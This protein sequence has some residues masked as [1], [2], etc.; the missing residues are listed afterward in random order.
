MS[1]TGRIYILGAGAIGSPLAAYLASAGRSVVAVRTSRNDVARDTFSIS[2]HNDVD[3]LKVSVETVSLSKLA[4]LE[5]IIVITAKSYA[6]KSI[7]LE[8][9]RKTVRGSL[10]IMQNGVGVERPFLDAQ[11]PEVHRCVLYV[12]SQE[13]STNDFAFRSITSSPM[14]VVKGSETDLEKVVGKLSTRGLP[15]HIDANI[16][17]EIWKKAIVNSV[18]NSICP[19]LDTDNGIFVRDTEAAKLANEVVMECIPLANRLNLALT[20][21]ELMDQI[22]LISKRSDGQLISTLQDI[23]SGRETEI[24]FLNLEMA[25]VA[26]SQQPRID[27]PRTELLGKMVLLKAMQR[28][29]HG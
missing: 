25:R 5:G 6:N 16:Q 18:F 22:M 21:S 4:S 23:K 13:T 11:F 20:A 26:A 15:I 9:K 1:E 3:N 19:L 7:A 24:E 27:L 17:R 29:T 12:T 28:K 2:V 10:V 14:G 8:L